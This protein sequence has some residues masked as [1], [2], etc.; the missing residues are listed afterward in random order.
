MFRVVTFQTCVALDTLRSQYSPSAICK[1]GS[2]IRNSTLTICKI[3]IEK[4]I[5]K[6]M[7]KTETCPFLLLQ[8]FLE[9]CK[10]HAVRCFVCLGF[11]FF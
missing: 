10:G 5:G 11:F 8:D 4:A 1:V 2:F 6:G 7:E 3:L 9:E